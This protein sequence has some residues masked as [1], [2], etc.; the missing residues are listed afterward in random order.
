MDP[1]VSELHRARTLA[2]QHGI[3]YHDHENGNGLGYANNGQRDLVEGFQQG[4]V[5]E[6]GPGVRTLSKVE[7]F[8]NAI[9]GRFN[10]LTG[11]QN[12][13]GQIGDAGIAAAFGD[14]STDTCTLAHN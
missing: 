4:I 3:S 12:F 14:S 9:D 13:M 10:K 8:T 1:M 11:A 2:L 6:C 7:G 5:N